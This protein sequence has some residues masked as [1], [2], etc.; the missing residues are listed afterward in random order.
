MHEGHA[1]P[2]FP[3]ENFVEGITNGAMWYIVTGGMQDWNYVFAGCMEL[4]I[5][6][7]CTKFPT[8]GELPGY[9]LDNRDALIAYIEQVKEVTLNALQNLDKL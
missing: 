5:E 8:S 1:C 6:L 4:T 2:L 7:G 9:W 3:K